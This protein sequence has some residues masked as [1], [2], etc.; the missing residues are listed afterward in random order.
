MSQGRIKVQK[1]KRRSLRNIEKD[2]LQSYVDNIIIIHNII[3]KYQIY[4][5]FF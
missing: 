1:I 3:I 5:L 4:E 2:K